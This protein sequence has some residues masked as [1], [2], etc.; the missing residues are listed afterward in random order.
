MEKK[1]YY[2]INRNLTKYE[3]EIECTSRL[4]RYIDVSQTTTEPNWTNPH[5]VTR[6]ESNDA[7]EP[8]K[9]IEPKKLDDYKFTE[10][11]GNVSSI[12]NDEVS[13]END[14]VI[15]SDTD[16]KELIVGDQT[17]SIPL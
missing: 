12:E 16:T 11:N 3:Y 1:N 5:C 17:C 6:S 9:C 15:V 13:C 4:C 8:D 7:S 2:K 10:L 14:E